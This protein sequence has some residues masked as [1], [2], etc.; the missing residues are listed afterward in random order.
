MTHENRADKPSKPSKFQPKGITILHE[1]QDILVVD[2]AAGLLTVGTDR[3]SERTVHFLL[4]EYVKKG[5][6]RSKNRVF[7]VHRLDR[8]TSGVLVFAKNE[9]TKAFLQENWAD[10]SKSYLT[11]VHGKLKEKKGVITT[12]LAENKVFRVFSVKDET[13]GKLAK[14]G[15][16]V[17]K[18]NAYFS[19]LE[20]NLFTGRKHQIRVHLSEK[21]HPVLGDKMYSKEAKGI[22]RLALH[23][24]TLTIIHP[25]SKKEMTFNAKAPLDFN[26]LVKF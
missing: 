6:I 21:G 24:S 23:S 7:V 14:T 3:E 20:I 8:E 18:E 12:Y 2:K 11:I 25:F 5:N 16:K 26:R 13:K 17:L 4:N 22:K 1:D 10:F 19:L 15:F 9:K